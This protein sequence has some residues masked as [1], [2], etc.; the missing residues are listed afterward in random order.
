MIES[1]VQEPLSEV[2]ETEVSPEGVP[3]APETVSAGAEPASQDT[4]VS[5]RPRDAHGRFMK[6]DGTPVAPDEQAALEAQALAPATATTSPAAPTPTTTA[7]EPFVF[8][9]DG[10]KIPIPG[11]TL[12]PD[13]SLSIPPD[14][15][16][17]IRQLLAEG[18]SHRG[19]WRQKEQEYQRRIEEASS[20]EKAR[21]DKYNHAA[22]FLFDKVNDPNWLQAL[23]NDPERELGLLRRELGLELKQRE[24]VAPRVQEQV[25]QQEPDEAQLTAAFGAALTDEVDE[26]LEDPRIR[27]VFS[28]EDVKDLKDDFIARMAAYAAQ[29]DGEYFVDR[30]AVKRAFDREVKLL[31][32]AQKAR[33]DAVK[34]AEFNARRAQPAPNLPPVVS[35]KAPPAAPAT[36]GTGPSSRDEWRKKMGIG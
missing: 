24:I 4:P 15:V 36:A 9:A 28:P 30:Q 27:G 1:E 5:D 12:A 2:E 20:V 7:G 22:V 8:R 17:V 14:Q 21:A 33:E 29:I 19:S 18:V 35:T 26:L 16:P 10:Q 11:S 13:G 32:R 6:R 23:V 31:Q 3:E 25:Q 34:A